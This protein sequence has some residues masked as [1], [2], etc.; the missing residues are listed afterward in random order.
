MNQ[1]ASELGYGSRAEMLRVWMHDKL[2]AHAEA[3]AA[4]KPVRRRKPAVAQ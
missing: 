2:K 4:S 1:M 3:K